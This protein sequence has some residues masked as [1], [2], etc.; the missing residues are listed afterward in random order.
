M[1]ELEPVSCLNK[2][3]CPD[4]MDFRFY[5]LHWDLIEEEL[6]DVVDF[7]MQEDNLGKDINQLIWPQ[8]LRNLE[9][10]CWENIDLSLV[11]LC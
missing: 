1:E 7:F 2:S 8:L 3:P 11:A 6:Y 10:L 4:H 5:R 9:L